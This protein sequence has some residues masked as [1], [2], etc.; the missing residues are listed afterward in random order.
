MDIGFNTTAA[1]STYGNLEIERDG[2]VVL[3]VW[4]PDRE[5]ASWVIA[6]VDELN[7]I[8][9]WQLTQQEMEW[10]KAFDR[11]LGGQVCHA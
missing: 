9:L 3:N 2:R 7:S 4:G 1:P 10:M 11:A 6:M 8:P 5:F